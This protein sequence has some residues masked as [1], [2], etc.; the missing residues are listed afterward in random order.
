MRFQDK[1]VVITG[2]GSGIGKA[3]TLRFAA[4]GAKIV[5]GEIDQ[6]R[7]DALVAELKAKGTQVVGVQ[8]NVAKVEDCN[9]LIDTAK[10]TFGKVDVLVNNA[11][12]VDRFMPVGEVT[13][14]VWNRVLGVNLYGPMY[15][16]RRVIPI[17]M[18]QKSGVI[19]N[20]TSAAGLI[21]GAAGAAYTTSKHG[22]VGLT[23]NTAFMY[24][25]DGIRCVAV[26]PGGINTGIPLGGDPSQFGYTRLGPRFT[27]LPRPG[28]PEQIA[29]VIAFLAS[30]DAGYI[31]GAVVSADAGWVAGG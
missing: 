4:E 30:E 5:A 3:T 20:L 21:G 19:V 7:L 23:K 2:A 8:G 13:D 10:E 1:V 12:I 17:M 22:V 6:A 28:E 15:T 11:G 31:N 29:S 16:S 24:G 26:A 27:A 14:E 25:A 9:K 18:E